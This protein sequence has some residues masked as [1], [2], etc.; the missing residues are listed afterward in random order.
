M[1][2]MRGEVIGIASYI[3]SSSGGF[4]GLGFVVTSNVARELLLT[5]PTPWTGLEGLLLTGEVAGVFN[6]PP[7]GG[8]L[9][10]RVAGGSPAARLGLRPGSIP[11][12]I[13]DEEFLVGGDIIIEVLGIKIDVEGTGYERI[14]ESLRR[15]GPRRSAA[16]DRTARRKARTALGELPTVTPLLYHQRG[17]A[18][19]SFGWRL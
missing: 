8:I 2:N 18:V 9:V 1:F 13:G 16:S 17:L 5:R 7:P 3:I 4:Q 15:L 14:Q 12:K 11:A 19:V 10:Q 6:V